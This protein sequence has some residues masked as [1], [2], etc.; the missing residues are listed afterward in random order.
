L[1]ISKSATHSL[2]TSSKMMHF[3]HVQ[4][5]SRVMVTYSQPIA[6]RN[7]DHN[8]SSN[9]YSN[10]NPFFSGFRQTKP[11]FRGVPP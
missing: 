4:Q 11:G 2:P 6:A 1:S 10:S 3:R 7:K 8:S 9:S 5:R